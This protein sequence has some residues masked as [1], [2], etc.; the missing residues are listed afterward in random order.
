QGY[1][2]A[3]ELHEAGVDVAGVADL[4]LEGESSEVGRQVLD[5]GIPVHRS[6]CVYEAH[7]DEHRHQLSAVVLARLDANLTPDPHKTVR[8]DCDGLL[9]SVGYAPTAA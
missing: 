3:L 2:Q 8:I 4:R 1:R 9:V 7:P 6:H 5:A